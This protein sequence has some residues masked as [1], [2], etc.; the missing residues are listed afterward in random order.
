MRYD[1]AKA[2]EITAERKYR[3]RLKAFLELQTDPDDKRHGT[4]WGYQVGC[5]CDRCREARR[6]QGRRA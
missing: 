6:L 5:R 3:V 4:M 1:Y 2:F